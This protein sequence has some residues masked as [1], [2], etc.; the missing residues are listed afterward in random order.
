VKTL[1]VIRKTLTKDFKLQLAATDYGTFLQNE[2][3]PIATVTIAEKARERLVAEFKY[4]RA[5]ANHPVAAFL[6]YLTYIIFDSSYSYMIDNVILLITG[7]LHER[8]TRELLDRCHPLGM[9]DSIGALSVATSVQE[10]YNTVL[11]DSPIGNTEFDISAA[12]FEKCLSAH[13]LDEMN[14][15]IIR[16]TLYKVY[17]EDFYEFCQSLGGPTA[18]A[19][20]DIL[21]V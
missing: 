19:M 9:F 13:D 20:G 1:T 21:R 17:L 7:T 5:N 3:S 14:I 11:V 8:D 18:E 16:N 4:L 12:Y 15:E 2:P 6:D 10:L